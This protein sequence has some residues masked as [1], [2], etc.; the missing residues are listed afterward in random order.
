MLPRLLPL[1]ARVWLG[2]IS[3]L[4]PYL[5]PD[6]I[7][8]ETDCRSLLIPAS[9]DWLAIVS[10]ALTELTKT[11]NWQQFGSV[12]VDEAV[13]AMQAMIDAYYLGCSGGCELPEGGEI[14]R[15]GE[16]GRIE[17][18]SDGEWVTPTDGD[19]YIPPPEAREGGTEA[20]Q[21]CL[22][23]KNAVNVLH[24]LYDQL[25]DYFNDELSDAAALLGLAAFMTT[26]TAFEFAPIVAGIAAF[27]LPIFAGV[28]SALSYLT[29]DLWDENLDKQ[30][31]CFLQECATNDAGVVTFDWD[32]FTGKLNSL[33]DE[34]GLSEVQLRFY[35]Q[36]S[37]LLLFIGGADGLNLAAG[38]TAISDDDCSFC[39]E[40][41]EDIVCTM[42]DDLCDWV[43]IATSNTGG[44]YIFPVYPG[45]TG[46]YVSSGGAFAGQGYVQSVNY[47]STGQERSCVLIVLP[48]ECPTVNAF[49]V[50][51]YLNTN[52]VNFNYIEMFD[53][54][55]TFIDDQT[56][57]NASGSGW[58]TLDWTQGVMHDVKYIM[59]MLDSQDGSVNGIGQIEIGL[60]VP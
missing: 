49:R 22:A 21:I 26:A 24:E 7:P 36:I 50:Y 25:S 15:I 45:T 55:M 6:S 11:W 51:R 20:D 9:T 5:T 46:T 33:T 29:A 13:D 8:E 41:C 17:V 27:L 42:V 58:H 35:L 37:Y 52:D 2:A 31:T 34:F 23:A 47:P 3:K 44:F 43:N 32:C 1:S 40:E 53:D 56:V 12:T 30:L 38:T 19:Y 59:V 16:D 14:I 48:D 60:D 28:Y 39:S 10:G 4:V 57:T 18:L 54:T